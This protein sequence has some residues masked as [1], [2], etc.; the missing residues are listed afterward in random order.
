MNPEPLHESNKRVVSSVL[1]TGASFVGGCG[2]TAN[3][4]RV[5]VE[6]FQVRMI[7]TRSAATALNKHKCLQQFFQWLAEDEQAVERSPVDGVRPDLPSWTTASRYL[8]RV[9][10]GGPSPAEP[11]LAPPKRFTRPAEQLD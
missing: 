1:M 3:I 8:Y 2:G 4:S 9:V 10:S 6:S 11:L 7:E 5:D